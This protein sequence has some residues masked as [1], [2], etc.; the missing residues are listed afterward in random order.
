MIHLTVKTQFT[1]R[2][3]P[4]RIKCVILAQAD[5][6]KSASRY[7]LNNFMPQFL[8]HLWTLDIVVVAEP[9]LAFVVVGAAAAPTVQDTVLVEGH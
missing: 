1:V 4:P 9:A 2:A 6:V 3:R 7:S 5:R 8:H